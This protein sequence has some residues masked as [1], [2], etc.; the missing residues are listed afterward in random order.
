MMARSPPRSRRVARSSQL[1]DEYALM[2]TPPAPKDAPDVVVHPPI[3][4]AGLLILGFVLTRI[5]PMRLPHNWPWAEQWPGGDEL[6]IQVAGWAAVVLGFVC[7][8]AAVIQFLR[9]RTGIPTF[10][11]ATTVVSDGIYSYTRNPM[12]A[13]GIALHAGVALLLDNGWLLVLLVP[14][15]AVLRYG[16]VAREEAYMEQKFGQ[17]YRD[18]LARVPRRF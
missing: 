1:I 11:A 5:R 3:L 18:Y 10:H 15:I 17:A 7:I 6:I 4:F 2:N 16:V 9:A 14:L 13:G 12:Y 8:G